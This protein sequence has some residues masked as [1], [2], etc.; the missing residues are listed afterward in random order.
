MAVAVASPVVVAS[1]VA[2]V[3]PVAVLSSYPQDLLKTSLKAGMSVPLLEEAVQL[4]QDVPKEA[5][6]H[7]ALSMIDGYEGNIHANGQII[8]QVEYAHTY[9]DTYRHCNLRKILRSDVIF[10]HKNLLIYSK[11]RR[12]LNSCGGLNFTSFTSPPFSE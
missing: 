2:V 11:N 5:N 4:M 3:S 6:D 8:L 12:R 9:I 7:M 1:P 10:L